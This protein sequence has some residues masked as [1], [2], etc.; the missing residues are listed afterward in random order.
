MNVTTVVADINIVQAALSVLGTLQLTAF[1]WPQQAQVQDGA[2]FDFIIVGAGAAG[3][4]IANRLTELENVS[5]LLIEAGGDPPTESVVPGLLIY[6]KNSSV[7]WNYLSEDDGYSYQYHKGQRAEIT[8]GKMLGGTSSINYMAYTR[9]NYHDFDTW[10]EI[11]GDEGWN[12]DNV[13]PY[14]IKSENYVDPILLSTPDSYFHGTDGYLGVT[15]YYN[16]EAIDY[17]K[18]FAEKGDRTVLD[19]NGATPLGYTE[20]MF[21]IKD[22]VRQSTAQAFLNPIKDRPNLFVLKNTLVSKILFD[23]NKNAI[24]VEAILENGKIVQYGAHKEVIVSG[25]AI[26]TPQILM[27]SGIGPESHLKSKQIE[28]ISDLPVG[29]T[30]QDHVGVTLVHAMGPLTPPPPADP[31]TFPTP[32]LVGFTAL[33]Q[34]Q[35]YA[36]YQ[37][38]SFILNDPTPLP[39]FCSFFF[40]Y[41]DEICQ[42]LSDETA[43]R[44]H[45]FSVLY[46]MSPESR[47]K[48]LLKSKDPKEYPLIY[49]GYYSDDGDLN[50]HVEYIKDFAQ[51]QLS[52]FFRS[53][54][55]EL[56]VP[57]FCGCGENDGSDEFWKCYAYCMMVQGYH[58]AGSCSMGAVVDSRLN[59]FGVQR[60]RVADASV[61]PKI[62][63]ANTNT[64]T[65]MI[66]ER[67][68][69]M[70][71]EDHFWLYK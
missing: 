68:A 51:V 33:N 53:V 57:T 10:A 15:R 24:G 11:T 4:V 43:G 40:H 54:N 71:K 56:I 5:V 61:M 36:D 69:D 16:E 34:S 14:F 9:G 13:L 59:V 21:N 49:T 38:L 29:Q 20:I 25:G 39:Q 60:L 18:A 22:R 65:I 50:K 27:L 3:S 8:R 17:F 1:L 23:E 37:T 42:Q 55:A 70:I 2:C 30:L 47:G 62:T 58:F 52:K 41:Y 48:I 66:G 45:F 31:G 12:W 44:E 35:G 26:N 64:A 19:I 46:V 7:D 28:V 6:M 67:V 63:R 32:L